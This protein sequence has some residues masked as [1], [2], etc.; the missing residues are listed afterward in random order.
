MD[1]IFEMQKMNLELASE[2]LVMASTLLHIKSRILLPAKKEEEIQNITQE[3]ID[4]R[5]ELVVRLI[6]YK[7]YKDLALK[8]KERESLWS[9][10]L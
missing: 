8:L 3:D 10:V 2:F 4:P 6:E 9:K 7:K 5:E 1:Y